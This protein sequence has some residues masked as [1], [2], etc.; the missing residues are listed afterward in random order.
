MHTG[1]QLHTSD[2]FLSLS[3]LHGSLYFGPFA[4]R[5][6]IL[7]FG[8]IGHQRLY[9]HM[10]DINGLRCYIH[11]EMDCCETGDNPSLSVDEKLKILLAIAFV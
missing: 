9:G 10:V 2:K 11:T 6:L 7:E 1:H 8:M 3:T 5:S 4:I